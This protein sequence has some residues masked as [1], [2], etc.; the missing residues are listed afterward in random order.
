MKAG[1]DIL[2]PTIVIDGQVVGTWTR[3]RKNDTVV[4][5]PRS[6]AKL[7]VAGTRALAAAAQRYRRFLSSS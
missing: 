2:S 6:F 3:A 1:T 7:G 4:M 5:T